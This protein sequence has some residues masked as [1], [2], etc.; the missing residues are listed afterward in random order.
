MGVGGIG[1]RLV[2]GKVRFGLVLSKLSSETS[3]Y[4]EELVG[5]RFRLWDLAPGVGGLGGGPGS[6][7]PGRHMW[8]GGVY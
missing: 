7:I 2:L 4:V 5:N 6:G 3:L 1:P 8:S